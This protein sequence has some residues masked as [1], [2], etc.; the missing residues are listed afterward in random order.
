LWGKDV[1]LSGVAFVLE[2]CCIW[3]QILGCSRVG[4]IGL[5]T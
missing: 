5:G 3:Y 1:W 4:W 2:F